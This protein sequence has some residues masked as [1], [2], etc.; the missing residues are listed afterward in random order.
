MNPNWSFAID[1]EI[2]ARIGTEVMFPAASLPTATTLCAECKTLDFGTPGFSFTYQ[3]YDLEVRSRDCGVCNMLWSLC[4]VHKKCHQKE[5]KFEKY[6][7]TLKMDDDNTPVLSMIR[8]PGM[9]PPKGKP[10]AY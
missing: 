9:S 10:S 4:V 2:P 6:H 7:S 1:T 5:V 8:S 3:I